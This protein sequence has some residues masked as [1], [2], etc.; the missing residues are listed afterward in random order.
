MPF[1]LEND[2]ERKKILQKM[3][4][5]PHNRS[6]KCFTFLLKSE[7]EKQHFNKIGSIN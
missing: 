7:A 5:M 3:G 6:F 2:K 4:N 1:D